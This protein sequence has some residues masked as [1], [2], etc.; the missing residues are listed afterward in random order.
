MDLNYKENL[1]HK[2]DVLMEALPYIQQFRDSVAVIKFGGSA[3]EDPDLTARTMRDIVLLEA[4]GMKVVVV[5][6]GGKAITARLKELNIETKFVN[7]LR[8]T[9]AATIGVVDDVLHN[10]VNRALVDAILKTGGIG[11]QI[12]GK[13]ILRCEKM[14]SR[15][16]ISGEESDVGFVGRVIGVDARPILDSLNFR[17]IPVITPL[18]MDF[19]G[20]PYN[21]NADLAACEIAMALHARKLVFISDVPGVLRDPKDETT[22]ISEIRTS[23]VP[24]LI[25]SGVLSGGMLPKIRSC[26][27][28]IEN[29]VTQVHMADGRLPHSL[30]LEIFTNTGVGTQIIKG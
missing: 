20:Q 5:H 1:I 30:L 24:G 17:I 9:D 19:H 25:E 13:R 14:L 18:A 28:A 16:P 22:L 23:A 27:N 10:Q 3:M 4:I 29:G 2:A 8:F 11:A 6:G 15:D 26:V 21:I 7:G 12:S